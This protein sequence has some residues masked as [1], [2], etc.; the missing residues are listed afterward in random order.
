MK[1]IGKL[2]LALS[3]K[4]TYEV[5]EYTDKEITVIAHP[6]DGQEIISYIKDK[7]EKEVDNPH[8][9]CVEAVYTSIEGNQDCTR[10]LG[11][12]MPMSVNPQPTCYIVK[13]SYSQVIRTVYQT[14]H[15]IT[16]E[17]LCKQF[18]IDMEELKEGK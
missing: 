18:G 11:G 2:T 8:I 10:W 13:F 5:L 7:V 15:S 9:Y 1:V 3:T 4:K 17:D 14:I 6:E 16:I 12:V